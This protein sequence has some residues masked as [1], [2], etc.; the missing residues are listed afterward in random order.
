[1]G[2]YIILKRA[3]EVT[4]SIRLAWLTEDLQTAEFWTKKS[5][6]L[7]QLAALTGFWSEWWILIWRNMKILIAE[8]ENILG[9]VVTY[10]FSLILTHKHPLIA[11]PSQNTGQRWIIYLRNHWTL[12]KLSAF[13]RFACPEVIISV[14]PQTVQKLPAHEVP[15]SEG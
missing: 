4:D 1:M 13:P 5:N 12:P 2:F 11:T 7:V 3:D 15:L 9:E 14:L 10:V 6:S 8:A